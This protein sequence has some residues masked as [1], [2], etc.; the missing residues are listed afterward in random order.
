MTFQLQT[1]KKAFQFHLIQIGMN[2]LKGH[3]STT[4]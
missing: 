2:L 3:D 4:C 1:D